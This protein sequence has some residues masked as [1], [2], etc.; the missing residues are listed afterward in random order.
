MAKTSTSL[1]VGVCLAKFNNK[2]ILLIDFDPQANLSIGLGV[3]AD[4]A[5]TMTP[6]LHGECPIKSV[7]QFTS[8]L[9]LILANAY[10]DGIE[11]TPQFANDICART[12]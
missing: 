6:V 11:R 12:T 4:K 10:L 2:R 5:R 3:G 7:I 1:H 9:S 8:G